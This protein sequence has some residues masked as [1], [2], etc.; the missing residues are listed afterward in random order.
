MHI[1]DF[2]SMCMMFSMLQIINLFWLGV[3]QGTGPLTVGNWQNICKLCS[4]FVFII[5]WRAVLK[6]SSFPFPSSFVL[7]TSERHKD[8]Q[9]CVSETQTVETLKKWWSWKQR[10]GGCVCTLS[11]LKSQLTPVFSSWTHCQCLALRHT[12][13]VGWVPLYWCLRK[14]V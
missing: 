14:T 10:W 9:V 1:G 12:W 6:C 7:T 3:V 4:T 8:I 13:Q 2:S 5:C 11:W